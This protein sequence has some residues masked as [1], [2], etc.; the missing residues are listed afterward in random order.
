MSTAAITFSSDEHGIASSPSL[1][2]GTAKLHVEFEGFEPYEGTITL[3]R[4]AMNQNITLKIAGLKE[5]VVVS[6]TT[7]EMAIAKVSVMEN[8]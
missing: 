3:R 6:D 7:V 8:S 2:V 4:G 1:P 5:E